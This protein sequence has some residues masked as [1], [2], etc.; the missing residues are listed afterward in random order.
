[1]VTPLNALGFFT[2]IAIFGALVGADSRVFGG[3]API[4]PSGKLSPG[5]R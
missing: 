3:W 5:P 4:E 2:L 1:M